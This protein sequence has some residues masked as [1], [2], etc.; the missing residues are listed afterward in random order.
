MKVI[1]EGSQEEIDEKRA[2][3]IKAIA[4][5]MY[6]VQLKRKD[7]R[8]PNEEGVPFFRAQAEMMKHWDHEFKETLESI[9]REINE[10]IDQ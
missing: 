1:I 6:D 9:K 7:E 10:I 2:D 4:G 8:S 5:S 3:L